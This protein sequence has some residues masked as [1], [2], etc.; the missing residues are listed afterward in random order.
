VILR[1]RERILGISVV[2]ITKN[3]EQN[4]SRCLES[5]TWA[6]EIVIVDSC[7]TDRTV[8]IC[9]NYTVRIFEQEMVDFSKQ[10]NFAIEKASQEW[11]FSID[12]DEIV[13][14]ELRNE[15]VD[16]LANPQYSCYFVPWQNMFWGKWLKHGGFY[17]SYRLRLFRKDIARFKGTIHETVDI[18]NIKEVGYLKGNLIH[19]TVTSYERKLRKSNLYSTLLATERA[20]DK[21]YVWKKSFLLTKPMRVFVIGY[22]IYLGFLDG[23]EGLICHLHNAFGEFAINVKIWE[24]R[25]ERN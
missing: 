25:E 12:A 24:I 3:E 19:N 11:I 17:P 16:T 7:S 14:K 22:F 23:F 5:V 18:S 2:I 13:S 10:K 21:N 6:D 8:D 4:I 15:I 9:R 20:Q 1:L